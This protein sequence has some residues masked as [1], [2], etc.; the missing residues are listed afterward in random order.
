MNF[1]IIRV[2]PLVV[3]CRHS[4]ESRN[5]DKGVPRQNEGR[6]E[7]KEYLDP[8]FHRNDRRGTERRGVTAEGQRS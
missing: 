6:N 1:K 7:G 3:V 5:P 2:L 8:G 4:G